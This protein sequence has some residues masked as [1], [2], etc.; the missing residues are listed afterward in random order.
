MLCFIVLLV[1]VALLK[2]LTCLLNTI[3]VA[4]LFFFHF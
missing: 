3:Y 4:A 1:L 2:V